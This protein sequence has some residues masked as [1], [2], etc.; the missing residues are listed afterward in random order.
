MAATRTLLQLRTGARQ[1]ADQEN[2]GFISDS[3]LTSYINYGCRKLYDLLVGAFGEQYYMTSDTIATVAGTQD[4]DLPDDFYQLVGVELQLS[5]QEYLTLRPF[6]FTKRNYYSFPGRY[7][8]SGDENLRYALV[9]Q[10]IRFVPIPN[11]VK[12]IR[13]DY[14]PAFTLLSADAD[15]FDGING[16]EDYVMIDAAI[17]M[18]QKEESDVNVLMA[19]KQEIEAKIQGLKNK[20]DQSFPKTVQDTRRVNNYYHDIY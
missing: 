8:I 15:T 1:L 6:G 14:V 2:S 3:E 4:Y 5:A 12:T 7:L 11:S 17:K 20:R 10:K 18:K 19:M 16:W 13:L 9:G